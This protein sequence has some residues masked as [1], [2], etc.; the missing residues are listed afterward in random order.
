MVVH[1]AHGQQRRDEGVVHS[2]TASLLVRKD[3]DLGAVAHLLLRRGAQRLDG[4]L[5]PLG[6]IADRVDR[7]GRGHFAQLADRAQLVAVEDGAG[8]AQLLG[9]LGRGRVAKVAPLAE[10]H[11][12]VH[13]DALA[14]WVDG[15]VGHL[16]EAL[17]KVVVERVGLLRQDGEGRVLTQGEESLLTRIGH[18][19]HLHLEVFER[20][21][22]R[23]QLLHQILRHRFRLLDVERKRLDNRPTLFEP[24]A[25]GSLRGKVTL[26]LLVRTELARLKVERDHVARAE[27]PLA[28]HLAVVH[29]DDARLGHEPEE[30]ILGQQVARGAQPIAIERGAELLAVAEDEECG[31]VPRL[32]QP[33]VVLVHRLHLWV[34]VVF[35]L[36]AIRL[37]HQ[38]RERHGGRLA[39]AP[40]EILEDGVE[41]RRVRLV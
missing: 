36:L 29:L 13:H 16:R 41:V 39:A 33:G 7:R 32:L 6:P 19:T 23:R 11:V 9:E 37:G 24:L 1:R 21:A 25:V 10:R 31:A 35:R 8:D 14:Q 20:P 4:L 12:K 3:N 5:E 17:L 2:H 38:D 27:P 22:K 40:H 30:P 28:H 26:D 15:W 34:V 18:I